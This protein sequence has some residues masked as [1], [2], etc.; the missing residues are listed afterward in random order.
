MQAKHKNQ[1]TV[2]YIVHVCVMY[3]YICINTIHI[4]EQW[5]YKY[6]YPVYTCKCVVTCHVL[7]ISARLIVNTHSKLLSILTAKHNLQAY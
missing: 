6:T 1:V 7:M 2:L 3:M 4:Y 5:E